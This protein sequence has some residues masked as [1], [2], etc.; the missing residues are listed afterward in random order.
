MNTENT[1]RLKSLFQEIKLDEP[2]TDFESRLMQRV[3]I[4]AA[5]QN[6]KR[7]II[8]ILSITFGIVGMLGIPTL[9]FWLLGLPLKEGIQ[10]MGSN[11]TF[12]ITSVGFNPFV[13]SVACVGVL[14]LISDSLIRRRIKEKKHKD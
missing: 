12:N 5:K 8:S 1:D 9:I 7:S 14:L 3:H 10:S 13:V 2:S 11:I 6:R 4:V